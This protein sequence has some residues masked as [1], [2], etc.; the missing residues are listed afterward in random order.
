VKAGAGIGEQ[1]AGYSPSMPAALMMRRHFSYNMSA[2]KFHADTGLAGS[3]PNAGG[4]M[5]RF[6][7]A[8]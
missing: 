4:G 5:R 2:Q 8:S 1:S 6:E 7:A 3:G